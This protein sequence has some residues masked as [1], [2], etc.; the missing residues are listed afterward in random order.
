VFHGPAGGVLKPDTVRNILLRSVLKPLSKQF[1]KLAGEDNLAEGRLH[2]FR[3]YFTS[4][5]ASSGK[6]DAETLMTWL[7][8]GDSKMVRHYF[9]VFED[10]AAKQ[11]Q[12]IEFVTESPAAWAAGEVTQ[13]KTE[14]AEAGKGA[15]RSA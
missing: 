1:P 9:H 2:S 13:P 12:T 4:A 7:G 5:A 10:R 14:D 15:C 6:V 3:H 8:H 11:M